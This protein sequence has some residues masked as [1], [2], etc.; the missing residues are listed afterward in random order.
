MAKKKPV[1]PVEKEEVADQA[2]SLDEQIGKGLTPKNEQA[3]LDQ[4]EKDFAL[5]PKFAKFK[6]SQGSEQP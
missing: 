6:K 4:Q 3:A 1:D 5:H 2:V